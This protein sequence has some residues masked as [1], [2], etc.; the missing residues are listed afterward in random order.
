MSKKKTTRRNKAT[1]TEGVLDIDMGEKG[2]AK[3]EW[4]MKNEAAKSKPRYDMYRVLQVNL[5]PKAVEDLE[6]KA[7]RHGVSVERFIEDALTY[8]AI[9]WPPQTETELRWYPYPQPY[10]PNTWP[11][12]SIMFTGADSGTKA[13]AHD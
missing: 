7:Q 9:K 5:P 4:S 6:K 10:D 8:G 1:K 12:G 2:V 3:C 11:P 13:E